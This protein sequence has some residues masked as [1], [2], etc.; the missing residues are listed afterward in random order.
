MKNVANT[1]DDLIKSVQPKS[2]CS[3]IQIE[4]PI[5]L[6]E[7]PNA[8][9][10]ENKTELKEVCDH[11]TISNTELLA[12]RSLSALVE[13]AGGQPLDRIKV[14]LQLPKNERLTSRELMSGGIKSFY[15][16]SMTSIIQRCIFYVPAIYFGRD[17]W[18]K[19][20]KLENK[21]SNA[22]CASLFT[23][24]LISPGV[25]IFENLKLEQQ[26]SR[27]QG[28]S[29]GAISRTLY[30]SYGLR[31]L[32]PSM[33]STFARE[34]VFA[35]G[36]CF[37]APAVHEV[38]ND[39]FGIDS[40]ILAGCT[41]GTITQA[42]THPFDTIKTWQENKKTGFARSVKDILNTQGAKFM[43]NGMLPRVARGCWTFTCLYYCTRELTS[44]VE[45]MKKS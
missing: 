16:A 4:A 44:L 28:K 24:A 36:I 23:G 35:G 45:K 2:S 21:Y 25:S 13:I 37:V 19:Y 11:Q 14:N 39:T 7:T 17:L 8:Y 38:L 31:G 1:F 9:K 3:A 42:L 32:F 20:G 6:V 27:N 22:I 10:D 15:A 40:V 34:A 29:M 5:E 18:D 30:A 33:G 43:Y 26:I 12:I 41:A